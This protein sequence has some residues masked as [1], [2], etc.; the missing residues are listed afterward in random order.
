MDYVLN[1]ILLIGGFFFLVKGADL[2][3]DGSSSVARLLKIPS[4]IIG[5]TIVSIGTSLPEAAV[6][7]TSSLQG[8]YD[9]SVA[10][11][12]GSNI[13][14]TLMVIGF[15][16]IICPFVADKTI[17]KNMVKD[18]LPITTNNVMFTLFSSLEAIMLP[19]MLFYY[20]NT[21]YDIIA[22]S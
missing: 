7:I 9:L 2:F 19:A 20:Y 11:V 13:F 5:L 17:L 14:N 21:I 15:S 1:L 16:A 4:V 6:S 18:A 10:N 3:V 12:V 8:S 22:I